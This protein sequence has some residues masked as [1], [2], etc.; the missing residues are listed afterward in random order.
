MCHNHNLHRLQCRN[1]LDL[2]CLILNL[3]GCKGY[4]DLFL[5][6]ASNPN[7]VM[8]WHI[9]REYQKAGKIRNVGISNYN[10][11]RL[12][13]FCN[14]IGNE[15]TQMIYANQIEFNPFLN[16]N[17]LLEKCKGLGCY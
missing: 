11:E 15:E 8:V 14:A 1:L 2:I 13:T 3:Q 17:D 7:D 4:V 16:R 10:I 9:L 5:I 6:H 12:D